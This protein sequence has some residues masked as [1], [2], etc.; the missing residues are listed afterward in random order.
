MVRND[1]HY[2]VH[3]DE[4]PPKSVSVQQG[5]N[6]MDIRFPLPVDIARSGGVALFRAVFAPGAEHRAHVHPNADEFYYVIRGRAAVGNGTEEREVEAGTIDFVPKGKI[7][8]LRNLDPNGEVE[9]LGG[10]LGVGSLEEAGYE[11]VG[12]PAGQSSV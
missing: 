4:V 10:Y 7:H 6:K 8:W 9:V 5:W 11:Y 1:N 12:Q 3:I 2:M